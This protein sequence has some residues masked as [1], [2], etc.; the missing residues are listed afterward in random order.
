MS[1]HTIR[2]VAV[3]SLALCGAGCEG[4]KA[5]HKA[6]LGSAQSCAMAT[7]LLGTPLTGSVSGFEQSSSGSS[8]RIEAHGSV[9]GPKGS[10]AI[11]YEGIS[12]GKTW[13]ITRGWIIA[14]GKTVDI[15]GCKEGVGAR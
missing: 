15:V 11:H 13:A 14:N 12:D 7:E 10:G 4:A 5:A 8:S 1:W 3:M 6:A 9:E 2:V